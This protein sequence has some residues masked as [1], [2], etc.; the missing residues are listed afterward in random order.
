MRYTKVTHTYKLAEA[1]QQG[2]QPRWVLQAVDELLELHFVGALPD[3]ADLSL[4]G[5]PEIMERL[6]SRGSLGL[7]LTPWP[8]HV[9][10]QSSERRH[11]VNLN[12]TSQPEPERRD[13]HSCPTLISSIMSWVKTPF[14]RRPS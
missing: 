9:L 4:G 8:G 3:C 13:L 2:E 6:D 10:S 11:C 1:G 5:T 14:S 7:G 12:L